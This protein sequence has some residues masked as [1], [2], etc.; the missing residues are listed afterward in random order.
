[1]KTIYYHSSTPTHC[2]IETSTFDSHHHLYLTSV[3]N[4]RITYILSIILSLVAGNPA[5]CT[6]GESG[7]RTSV[8]ASTSQASADGRLHTRLVTLSAN[9]DFCH[10]G[11]MEKDIVKTFLTRTARRIPSHTT[12]FMKTTKQ[13][14]KWRTHRPGPGLLHPFESTGTFADR[15]KGS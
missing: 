2:S 12:L 3:S 14:C 10:W 4:L 9:S 13:C 6:S 1:M 7:V 11:P 5:P 8:A 15:Y